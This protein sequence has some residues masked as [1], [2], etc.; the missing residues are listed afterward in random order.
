[1]DRDTLSLESFRSA[2]SQETV[3]ETV[4]D[5]S[6]T[7]SITSDVTDTSQITTNSANLIQSRDNLIQGGFFLKCQIKMGETD[8]G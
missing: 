6:E 5:A 8:L 2:R 4:L 1:M 3:T 7:I